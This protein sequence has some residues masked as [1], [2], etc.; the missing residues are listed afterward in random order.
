MRQQRYGYF[1]FQLSH[2]GLLPCCFND[3][4]GSR[5]GLTRGQVA[6]EDMARARELVRTKFEDAAWTARI[7]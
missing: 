4:L 1:L 5:Y 2:V 3:R 6:K 7:P